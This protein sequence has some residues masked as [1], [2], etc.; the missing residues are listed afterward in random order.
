MDLRDDPRTVTVTGTGAAAGTPDVVVLQV[1]IRRDAATV[2]DALTQVEALRR[3]VVA[4][5]EAAGVRPADLQTASAGVW[6]NYD[7]NGQQV[8][9]YR[10][11]HALT[12]T[13]RD[14]AA[15]GAT[16]GAMAQAAG[17]AFV[18]NGLGLAVA[19]EGPLLT[20]ARERA[21]A[22]AAARAG[23]YASAAG[24]TLGRVLHVVAD[25]PGEPAAFARA[26][27]G[28]AP[29]FG[30]STGSHT[31]SA[32]VSVTWQLCDPADDRPPGGRTR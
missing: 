25:S 15:V 14:A 26:S 6:P 31:V 4:A 18:L 7:P 29:D 3:Q 20:R 16:T 28:G 21:F 22:D 8:V 17:D 1:A 5:A 23:E 12:A 24:G 30:V 13:V 27:Y 19:D 32:R 10:A 9:G 2:G 11:E